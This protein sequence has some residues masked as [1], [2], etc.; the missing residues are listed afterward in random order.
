MLF[1]SY[2]KQRKYQQALDKLKECVKEMKKKDNLKG[3]NDYVNQGYAYFWIAEIYYQQDKAEEANVFMTLCQEI[4]KEYSPG[5]LSQTEE[6]LTL[7]ENKNM[8]MKPNQKEE[9]LNNFLNS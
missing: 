7:L 2:Q 4:W 1:R 3:V 6:L 9:V 5:L 8:E